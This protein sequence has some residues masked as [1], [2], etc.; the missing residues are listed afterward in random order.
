VRKIKS[1]KKILA[2]YIDKELSSLKGDSANL[3]CDLRAI[4]EELE[5]LKKEFP[6]CEFDGIYKFV[7]VT[8]KPITLNNVY[9]GPFMIQLMVDRI[10]SELPVECFDVIAIE[11]HP[12]ADNPHV[13]HPHVS[14]QR[15]CAGDATVPISSALKGGRICDCFLL[16]HSVLNTYNPDSPFVP[17][18]EWYGDYKLCYDCGLKIQQEQSYNC[19]DCGH[20]FCK[21]C[22]IKFSC[23]SE[24]ICTACQENVQY[25]EQTQCR[26]CPQ[27][28]NHIL[29]LHQAVKEQRACAVELMIEDG[30]D[31]DEWDENGK[32]PL[33]F[34]IKLQNLEIIELL[35]SHGATESLPEPTISIHHA[36]KEGDV[37][38]IKRHIY[39]DNHLNEWAHISIDNNTAYTPLHIAAMYGQLDAARL[40]LDN[41]ANPNERKGHSKSVY[42]WGWEWEQCQCTPLHFAVE[43]GNQ[44]MIELLLNSGSEVDFHDGSCRTPLHVAAMKGHCSIAKEFIARGADVNEEDN[45]GQ[46]PLHLAA[47]HGHEDVVNLLIASGSD[48][49]ASDFEHLTPLHQAAIG[50]HKEITKILLSHKAKSNVKDKY[51]ITP[52]EYAKLK[53]NIDIVKLLTR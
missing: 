38:Q 31:V 30:W 43:A 36:A 3:E 12:A 17:L 8:T 20:R 48:I 19:P 39:H 9:L 41:S 4:Y 28:N 15:L 45:S 11:P 23:C 32:K 44:E 25:V 37:E 26:E 33:D 50:N 21:D 16:I 49:N 52:L 40:L 7:S 35:R 27:R 46:T 13:T 18:E 51:D 6:K 34:A 29:D 53:K 2:F 47:E 1:A 24:L 42:G 10:N 5:Q 22:I 14:S